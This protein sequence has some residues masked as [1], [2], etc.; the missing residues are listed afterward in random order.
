ML[1]QGVGEHEDQVG[2]DDALR[3]ADVVPAARRRHRSPAVE[4]RIVD[5]PLIAPYRVEGVVLAALDDD[6]AVG[7][8]GRGIKGR[9]IADRHRGD[10]RPGSVEIAAAAV[11]GQLVPIRCPGILHDDRAVAQ[12]QRVHQFD[13]ELVRQRLPY[14]ARRRLSLPPVLLPRHDRQPSHEALQRQ[15]VVPQLLPVRVAQ[16]RHGLVLRL[17]VR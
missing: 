5:R 15:R 13:A 11:R 1:C 16:R 8:Y 4:G 7:Q 14:R 3:V 9:G 10:L 12:Q 17:R 2:A 6:P